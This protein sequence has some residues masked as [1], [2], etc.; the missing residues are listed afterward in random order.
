MEALRNY[1]PQ[2]YEPKDIER[3]RHEAQRRVEDAKTRPS[4]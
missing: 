3:E 1:Q 2:Y 4:R